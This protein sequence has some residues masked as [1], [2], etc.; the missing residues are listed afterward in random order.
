MVCSHENGR[1]L[2]EQ[3]ETQEDIKVLSQKLH[4]STYMPLTKMGYKPTPSQVM[5]KSTQRYGCKK[6]VG[7]EINKSIYDIAILLTLVLRADII[8][9]LNHSFLLS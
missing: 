4:T 2:R 6:R 8:D 5:E 3:V 1:D 9:L 7:I